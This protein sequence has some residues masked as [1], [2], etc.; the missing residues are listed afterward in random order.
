[1]VEV[2][3]DFKGL[4]IVGVPVRY[5]NLTSPEYEPEAFP[6]ERTCWAVLN[7]HSQRSELK[8]EQAYSPVWIGHQSEEQNTFWVKEER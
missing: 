6:P 4:T 8:A 5:R 7:C 2:M 3:L 1:M